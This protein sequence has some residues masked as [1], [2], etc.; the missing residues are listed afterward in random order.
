MVFD[1]SECLSAKTIVCIFSGTCTG[2]ARVQNACNMR[3]MVKL[4]LSCTVQ[5]PRAVRAYMYIRVQAKSN[6]KGVSR[7]H[8]NVHVHVVHVN[9]YV[10]VQCIYGGAYTLHVYMY[11]Y[12][13]TQ[14]VHTV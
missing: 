6:I 3:V 2:V 12:M 7:Q 13:C 1:E 8:T 5:V 9:V 11:M 10:H 4:P 14:T